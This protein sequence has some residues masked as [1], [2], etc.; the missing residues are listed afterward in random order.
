MRGQTNSFILH[1]ALQRELRK[2]S[3]DAERTFWRHL[4]NRQLGGHKFRRQHPYEGYVLDFACMERKLV[5]EADGGQHAESRRDEAR[6]D[7]L[8]QAGFT[9]LRFWNNEVLLQTEAVLEVI[10]RR[11]ENHPHPGPLLEGEGAQHV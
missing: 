11:L 9:V 10:L 8:A 1:N 4:R 7:F 6:D 3:T 5:V 2:T